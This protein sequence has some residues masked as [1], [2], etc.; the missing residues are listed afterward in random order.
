MFSPMY[1]LFC[2][3]KS[4]YSIQMAKVTHSQKVTVQEKKQKKKTD[5]ESVVIWTERFLSCGS[6]VVIMVEQVLECWI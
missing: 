5:G 2:V 6:M 4:Q 1:F 3:V